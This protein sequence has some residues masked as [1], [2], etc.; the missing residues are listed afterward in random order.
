MV[1]WQIPNAYSLDLL[2]KYTIKNPMYLVLHN[3]KYDKI[4]FILSQFLYK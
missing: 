3:L 1:V 4:R 2:I